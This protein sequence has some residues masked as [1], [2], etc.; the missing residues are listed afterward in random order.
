MPPAAISS[1]T[2]YRPIK[3]SPASLGAAFIAAAAYHEICFE[4]TK[5]TSFNEPHPSDIQATSRKDKRLWTFAVFLQRTEKS[6]NVDL[7]QHMQELIGGRYQTSVRLGAGG[8]GTVYAATDTTTGSYV[9]VKVVSTDIAENSVALL[10]FER[11]VRAVRALETPHVVRTLDAGRDAT[12]GLPFLVMEVLEGDDAAYVIK[13][14]KPMRPDVVL[15]LG[16]Q[17]CA[18]LEMAH[19]ARIVHRDIK[20]SN[21]FF[22]LGP[23]NGERTIKILDFG[24]AKL[25][26]EPESSPDNVTNLTKTGHLL[27]SPLYMAPEQARGQRN[28]DE[29]VDIFSLGVV[30]YE[31][32]TGRTPHAY[33][34]AIGELIVTICTEPAER[35][36]RIAPWV[37]KHIA[38][39]VH[40]ALEIKPAAR[41]Q[42]ITE[43]RAAL[44]A[45]LPE[46]TSIRENM[47]VTIPESERKAIS[48]GP[49]VPEATPMAPRMGKEAPI[50][51]LAPV[52]SKGPHPAYLVAAVLAFAALGGVLSFF[53]FRKVP[54]NRIA[55]PAPTSSVVEV[56]ATRKVLVKIDPMD[57]KVTV[58]GQSVASQD[59]AITME[60][61]L[62][63]V[64][65]VIVTVGNRS[66]TTNVIIAEQGA[67]PERLTLAPVASTVPKANIAT[68]RQTAPRT[69]PTGK[70]PHTEGIYMGR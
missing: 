20:P 56:V 43:M 47:L 54:T 12:S 70:P 44:L 10:R 39:V 33:T 51:A 65:V 55:I 32:L 30:L 61:T 36:E 13:R 60:G 26:P 15:R 35:I 5:R 58:D 67:S 17:V 11:E 52:A 24:L 27:G 21:L 69:A 25:M 66:E 46:G 19:A 63:S 37:P 23:S 22:G 8:M 9:A 18:G 57:A 7:E 1:W 28:V 45:C 29:R 48:T 68:T 42:S 3:R 49:S 59:G 64:H 34:E 38:D 50:V 4:R 41:Y 2:R 40:R 14:I 62:G 53:Y 16:A 31:A 6:L